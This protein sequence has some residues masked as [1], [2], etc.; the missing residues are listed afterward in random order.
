MSDLN[1]KVQGFIPDKNFIF[2]HFLFS[3][4]HIYLVRLKSYLLICSWGKKNPLIR[5]V[6]E[7][8]FS[9]KRPI[10]IA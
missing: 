2:S 6:K 4:L 7:H 3:S 9:Y 1:Q 5:K 8:D 10:K